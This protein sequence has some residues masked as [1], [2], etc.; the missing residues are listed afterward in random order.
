MKTSAAHSPARSCGFTLLEVLIATA[1]GAI[2]LLVVN[3]T[4]FNA[5]RLHNTTHDRLA[6][7][8]ELARALGIVRRDL[9]GVM[10]PS[11]A[12]V[13]AGQLQTTL[14]SSL[15]QS[16]YGDKVGPDF[17]TNSG[18]VDGWSSFSEV[19]L[20][21]YYLTAS[22]DGSEAK[23]L[24]RAVTRNLLPAQTTTPDLQPLLTQVKEATID[25]YDGTTWTE[26]WDSSTS[27]TLPKAIRFQIVRATRSGQ[28]RER[29][30][31]TL[32]VP[33]VVETTT[34]ASADTETSGGSL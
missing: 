1:V 3:A 9:A 2:V 15:T 23:T 33:V 34:S 20:V 13:L 16:S 4:F 22:S 7:D 24:V 18:L 6:E 26:S 14:A 28:T 30:P 12:G 27:S 17:Y 31:V 32:I 19:Q 11:S 25:F 29:S 5:V 10:L 21:D 8:L